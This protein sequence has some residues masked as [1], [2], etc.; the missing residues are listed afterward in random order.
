MLKSLITSLYDIFHH[1]INRTSIYLFIH[2]RFFTYATIRS[3][4]I[5]IVIKS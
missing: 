4:F 3:K 5:L 1:L 2:M